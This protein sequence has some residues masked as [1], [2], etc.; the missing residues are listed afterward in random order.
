VGDV[1]DT[2]VEPFTPYQKKLFALLGVA[3]FFEGFDYFA[4]TQLLP[5]LRALWGLSES[6]GTLMIAVM[7][8]GTLLATFVVRRGDFLGRRRIM[9][10][11]IVGYTVSSFLSGLATGP[12]FFTVCQLAARLFLASEWALAMVVAAEEFPASRRGY[13]VGLIQAFSSFG[14][15]VCAGVAPVVIASPLTWRGMYFI[16]ALPLVMMI[17]LRRSLQETARFRN[18]GV[19]DK[20]PASLMRIWSTRHRTRVVQVAVVWGLTYVCTNNAV[21][22]WKEFAVSERGMTDGEVGKALTIAALASLPLVFLAGKLLDVIGRRAASVLIYIGIAI[23]VYAIY[24]LHDVMLMTVFLTLTIV[25][26][27]AALPLVTA[28]TSE[29]FP[30]DMRADAYA[31]GNHLLGRITFVVSPLV[32]GFVADDRAFGTSWGLGMGFGAAVSGTAAFALVAL[33][34]V[35]RWMPETRGK[36]LEETAAL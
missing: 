17:V 23:S 11:T 27:N 21:T 28:F 30:T 8:V 2:P 18:L 9:T 19:D 14:A 26:V 5:N 36:E 12:V 33:A 1:S 3:C 31:W 4:I 29:L 24:A 16:G 10:L 25:S 15:I 34:L 22:F 20:K 35:L 32:I 13:V 7:S 6:Q